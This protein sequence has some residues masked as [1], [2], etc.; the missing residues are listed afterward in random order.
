MRTICCSFIYNCCIFVYILSL[1]TVTNGLINIHGIKKQ[2]VVHHHP[3][4][5][6]IDTNNKFIQQF[7]MLQQ[8]IEKEPVEELRFIQP[9][10]NEW[11]SLHPNCFR[12][13]IDNNDDNNDNSLVSPNNNNNNNNNN[14]KSY[15]SPQIAASLESARSILYPWILEEQHSLNNEGWSTEWKAITYYDRTNISTSNDIDNTNSNDNNQVPLHGYLIRNAKYHST[16]FNQEN[17]GTDNDSKTII[18]F[19]PT[20]VGVHDLFLLYKASQ[21]VNQSSQL[22][23]CTI[24]ILDLFS[25]PSG[26]LWDKTKYM[27]RYNHVRNELLQHENINNIQ[28][29]HPRRPIL[30]NRIHAAL[31]YIH[32]S[33]CTNVTTTTSIAALGWCFGGH[34]IAEL[35]RM[36]LHHLF[37]NNN[38][39]IHAMI[40]FH[41][42]FS[43]LEI[44]TMN[45]NNDQ[46][47]IQQQEEEGDDNTIPL[48]PKKRSEILICHGLQDPFVPSSDLEK[49]LYVLLV[50]VLNFIYFLK[51]ILISN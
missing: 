29:Q 6:Y 20:A 15:Y 22:K 26:W 44:P 1:F 14:N 21:I 4:K 40:T 7:M 45:D 2:K 41:G 33:Y 34:C 9:D 42:V 23:H 32:T 17:D 8:Q 47:N 49:A 11:V 35:A 18:L 31:D 5:Q 19:F 28:Q 24:M 12:R 36:D 50:F 46:N 38:F 13:Y 48:P 16:R 51:K 3:L 30:Q 27:D 43:E 10:T 39:P 37:Q 25:D